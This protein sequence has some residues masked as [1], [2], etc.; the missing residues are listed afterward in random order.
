MG[1]YEE[2]RLKVD[3]ALKENQLAS[4]LEGPQPNAP[5]STRMQMTTGLIAMTVLAA[6]ADVELASANPRESLQ[7]M[8]EILAGL[9]QAQSPLCQWVSR[10][11][12]ARKADQKAAKQAAAE[13]KKQSLADKA[14]KPTPSPAPPPSVAPSHGHV[15]AE[16]QLPTEITPMPPPL[17]FLFNGYHAI[18]DGHANIDWFL[19]A[20]FPDITQPKAEQQSLTAMTT[21]IKAQ[22]DLN[23]ADFI[24]Q[25]SPNRSFWTNTLFALIGTL[26]EERK[27]FSTPTTAM[28]DFAFHEMFLIASCHHVFFKLVEL[29]QSAEH[30]KLVQQSMYQMR[31]DLAE[32]IHIY[33]DLFRHQ[34]NSTSLKQVTL[35]I[36]GMVQIQYDAAWAVV[37]YLTSTSQSAVVNAQ[38]IKKYADSM[39]TALHNVRDAIK[40]Q[41][42]VATEEVLKK[43][44]GVDATTSL[45]AAIIAVTKISLEDEKAVAASIALKLGSERTQWTL[46]KFELKTYLYALRHWV[47]HFKTVQDQEVTIMRNVFKRNKAYLQVRRQATEDID[48]VAQCIKLTQDEEVAIVD[49]V[50]KCTE[51]S[52]LA[53]EKI[54]DPADQQDRQHVLDVLVQL[55]Q[56][57][58]AFS[59][60]IRARQ[61]DAPRAAEHVLSEMQFAA[62]W[63]LI[64]I[65][66][67]YLI[68]SLRSEP[69]PAKYSLDNE[70]HLTSMLRSYERHAKDAQCEW[71]KVTNG[72]QSAAVTGSLLPALA[73]GVMQAVWERA[74]ATHYFA[75]AVAL[76]QQPQVCQQALLSGLAG[77]ER[78]K[79]SA[80]EWARC[81]EEAAVEQVRDTLSHATLLRILPLLPS[82]SGVDIENVVIGNMVSVCRK[83]KTDRPDALKAAR[84]LAGSHTNTMQNWLRP[85]LSDK[86]RA[87]SDD[88][89]GIVTLFSEWVTELAAMLAIIEPNN[90]LQ[91]LSLH[92]LIDFAAGRQAIAMNAGASHAQSKHLVCHFL[93]AMQWA[94]VGLYLKEIQGC[95]WAAQ[96]LLESA[97]PR[98]TALHAAKAD[99][100]IVRPVTD[101]Q[102]VQVERLVTES[103]LAA[104][105]KWSAASESAEQPGAVFSDIEQ[106]QIQQAV[107]KKITPLCQVLEN[108]ADSVEIVKKQAQTIAQ[109]VQS[110]INCILADDRNQP[111]NHQ[112]Q[113][114]PSFHITVLSKVLQQ[115]IVLA[116]VSE[117]V[118][119]EEDEKECQTPL[120]VEAEAKT[121]AAAGEVQCKAEDAT[122]QSKEEV[123]VD[124]LISV[125]VTNA[126]QTVKKTVTY[127]QQEIARFN[128]AECTTSSSSTRA[129]VRTFL[130]ALYKH[131]SPTI[132]PGA[133]RPNDRAPE[134]VA[135]N[136]LVQFVSEAHILA[137]DA[138][139]NCAA[140][141]EI[142]A[143]TLESIARGIATA[144]AQRLQRKITA[145]TAALHYCP[146]SPSASRSPSHRSSRSPLS[147]GQFGSANAS[148][149]S[150]PGAGG[151]ASAS[152]SPNPSPLP[153]RRRTYS[154]TVNPSGDTSVA[155]LAP[156]LS[157]L[158]GGSP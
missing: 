73:D 40:A 152:A 124:N 145:S 46:R 100:K 21:A 36:L 26:T 102:A 90:E 24:L 69:V 44:C 157:R 93:E 72:A 146:V 51:S 19:R 47:E 130:V 23:I 60:A 138:L 25:T 118:V 108:G 33:Q 5:A 18:D 70:E 20:L 142:I 147:L 66:I 65:Q 95:G 53:L 121:E 134:F 37:S 63:R 132:S 4:A 88:M 16:S 110:K 81:V 55:S 120:K 34:N 106:Q 52:L 117:Q 114:Q 105:L 86:R 144:A 94:I 57:I 133:T 119:R 135:V 58:A 153:S 56:H 150:A 158:G 131:M 28:V 71:P 13:K 79:A 98:R 27:R 6:F 31:A 129:N 14:E 154:S 62:L 104:V 148:N 61:H 76:P 127:L 1:L 75:L 7:T 96:R 122:V 103:R 149:R 83:L 64:I 91:S 38:P 77:A 67:F 109:A 49:Q 42:V 99:R 125:K 35:Q 50:I 101:R 12:E 3:E 128:E 137:E 97:E 112:D 59:V 140:R 17:S 141:D 9:F 41:A 126:L 123:K 74:T 92:E 151:G 111:V 8:L 155:P 54:A 85:I 82:R 139:S 11:R 78:M 136:T 84:A 89:A 143:H 10:Q 29:S 87:V 2:V 68:N 113:T 80:E 15:Q 45:H 116:Q 107:I 39:R 115:L 32:V 22:K 30:V 48:K 156:N 43:S